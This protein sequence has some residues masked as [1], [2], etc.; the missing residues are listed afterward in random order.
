MAHFVDQY[1]FKLDREQQCILFSIC[2]T[3]Q[4]TI[5]HSIP[6]KEFAL[7]IQ[8]FRFHNN[9]KS[10]SLKMQI[11]EN[12]VLLTVR[13]SA[14]TRRSYNLSKSDV[15]KL[16]SQFRQ[17][18][19]QEEIDMDAQDVSFDDSISIS[20]SIEVISTESIQNHNTDIE[21]LQS[22]ITYIEH[23]IKKVNAKLDTILSKLESQSIEK[24]VTESVVF[25]A[26]PV[27]PISDMP[28][29]IPST[30]R[31]DFEGRLETNQA[32]ATD[33]NVQS[34]SDLLKQLKKGK[35]K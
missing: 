15:Q 6:A 27:A 2:V 20:K 19:N 7:M 9:F 29:F 12:D 24:P 21:Q 35:I 18:I 13:T 16:V 4:R 14:T 26:T 28:M 11:R 31:T 5:E 25:E 23:S 30:V 3:E 22:A 34:A 1:R 33:D 17:S 10:N 8:S 32:K